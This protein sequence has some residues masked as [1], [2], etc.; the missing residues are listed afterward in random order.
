M[1]FF[2]KNWVQLSY[3]YGKVIPSGT[4]Q[5]KVCQDMK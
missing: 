2:K 5:R 4:T 3:D 1:D